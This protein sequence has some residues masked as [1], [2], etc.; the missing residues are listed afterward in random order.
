M[1]DIRL[2]REDPEGIKA[3]ARSKR[4]PRDAEVDRLVELDAEARGILPEL[5]G[6]RA[7]QKRAGKAM[8]DAAQGERPALLDRQREVKNRIR[9][10]EERQKALREELD[11]LLL[12]VPN[13]P[14]AGVPQGA[15][16]EQNV[17][18]RAWGEP[19][20]FAFAPRDHVDLAELHGLADFVR[21]GRIA[22]SRNYFLR[23]KAV[24]LE[25]AVLRFALD[26]MAARGFE[27]LTVP[28]LVRYDAM[29]GTGYFPGG[30][31]QAYLVERDELSLVGT[32]EVPLTS[33]FG[34]E[35][36]EQSALPVRLVARS[37]CF[38]REAGTYGKDTRGLYRVHQFQKVE[39]V[40]V[41]AADEERSIAHQQEILK[42][43]E[44]LLQA[45]ELPYRVVDVCTGELGMGQVRKF[46][47]ECWMPS[48]GGY[49][50]TH[51]AS[52]FHEF[53]AR[54]LNLRYRDGEGRVRFCHTLNNTVVASPRILIPLLEVHQR[55]DGSVRIPEALHPYLPFTQI[56]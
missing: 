29:R 15:T 56:P 27:P 44:E 31:E 38:R 10:L 46:D 37:V 36:L 8:A 41:D 23:G 12:L 49:G 19:P 26:S 47:I 9:E 54:R 42:N 51:S 6:L 50:E 20:A 14:D 39:Q 17:P 35:I 40:V 16:E 34:G 5:E 2:I 43:A 21:A 1:L 45:L 24:L 25:E 48:R 32:S 11:R 28:V 30:E 55:E 52:R 22:G 3:G 33:F 7:E 18:V 4:I 53:Q 13:P